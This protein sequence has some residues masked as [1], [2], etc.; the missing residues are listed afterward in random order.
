MKNIKLILTILLLSGLSSCSDF[1]DVSTD[2]KFSDDYVFG[3]KEE[4]NRALNSVYAYLLSND[5]YGNKFYNTYA[6]NNDVEFTTNS[7]YIQSTSG[8]EYKQ[9]DATR[10]GSDLNSTWT[11]AYKCIEYANIFITGA[12]ANELYAQGD[13]LI[14]QQVGEAKCLRAMNYHD[15]VVLFGDIPFSL[16]RSYDMGDNLVMPLASR[17]SILTVLINDLRE[18]A[19][20]MR[21][22]RDLTDGV[23]R[24]SK[25]FCWSLIARMA[26]TRSGYSLRPD[27]N[28][29]AIGTMERASDYRNYYEIARQYCDSVISSNTHGLNKAYNEVFIDQCNYIV[30]NSDDPI[31][32]IPF[33]KES[34]GNV[35]Y[36]WGPKGEVQ[37]D[38]TTGMNIWG[39]SDGG[40]RLNAFYRFSFDRNDLRLYSIGMWY[41]AYDGTPAILNDYNNYCNKWSKFWAKSGNAQGVTS[42]GNTGINYPYMRYADVLLM[43]AEAINELEDGVTSANGAKAIAAFKEVRN[44]AFAPEHRG[45]KVDVYVAANTSKND[46]FKILM[47]ERKWEFGGENMR[48]K[49]LVRWN[50]YAE[51]VRDVFYD[52]YGFASYIGG[53]N[54]YN[55]DDRFDTMP[56]QIFWQIAKNPNDVNIYPNTTLDVLDLYNPWKLEFH[57]GTPWEMAEMYQWYDDGTSTPKAQC[58]YSLRGYIQADEFGNITPDLWNIP[59]ENLPVVRYILPFPASVIQRSSGAYKNYYG[60]N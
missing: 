52:Y 16:T 25:E 14:M 38:V 1:L 13:T 22:A 11:A 47:N 9:F 6:L 50:K 41:Y 51:V 39:K 33:L 40:I 4:I 44:R 45:E 8:N 7:N 35:G 54:F 20:N 3:S 36:I 55:K 56:V 2:S 15:M 24:A 28:P 43:Y 34:S 21:F 18:V 23:E 17:D 42:A 32:E 49:D 31:F 57:P 29:N 58:R 26:M 30:D 53:D 10:S 27:A 59:A 48:W 60:Y 12:E 46:F 37:D 19:P 5:T